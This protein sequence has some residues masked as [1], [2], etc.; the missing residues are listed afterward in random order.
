MQKLGFF[1]LDPKI[2]YLGLLDISSHI[3]DVGVEMLKFGVKKIYIYN[4]NLG[5]KILSNLG[6]KISYLG[7]FGLE[8]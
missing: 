2:L 8:F 5:P 3:W 6:L 7:N 1:N 4:L